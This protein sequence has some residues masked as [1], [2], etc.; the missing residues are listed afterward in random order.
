[1]DFTVVNGAAHD[2]GP[3]FA[4]TVPGSLPAGRGGLVNFVAA[5]SQFFHQRAVEDA[6]VRSPL[7]NAILLAPA[8]KAV[9]EN[10]RILVADVASGL[11]LASECD[12]AHNISPF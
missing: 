11:A 9:L 5:F 1:M 6:K 10:G 12:R 8:D 3:K 7:V 2:D 4:A